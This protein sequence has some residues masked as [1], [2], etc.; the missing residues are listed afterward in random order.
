[1]VSCCTVH[2]GD[3][4]V[5]LL[6]RHSGMVSCCTVHSD[7][8]PVHLL[9]RHSDVYKVTCSGESFFLQMTP[10]R[11]QQYLDLYSCLYSS[12]MLLH[13]PISNLYTKLVAKSIMAFDSPELAG[14][15]TCSAH[16][17]R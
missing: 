14:I 4:P 13:P 1:M 2:S 9:H 6:H 12:F 5:H 7:D 17:Q 8:K 11:N 16:S 15:P 10:Q 3:K